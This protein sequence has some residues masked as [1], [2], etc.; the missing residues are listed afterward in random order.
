MWEDDVEAKGERSGRVRPLVIIES[1]L[2]LS[3][4]LAGGRAVV[5]PSG[6]KKNLSTGRWPSSFGMYSLR[7]V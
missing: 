4:G 1:F 6:V 7:A 2:T 3:A 5:V